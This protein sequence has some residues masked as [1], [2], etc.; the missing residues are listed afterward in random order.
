MIVHFE[1][2]RSCPDKPERLVPPASDTTKRPTLF[3][4][5]QLS[6]SSSKSVGRLTLSASDADSSEPVEPELPDLSGSELKSATQ[7]EA[8]DQRTVTLDLDL[9]QVLEHTTALAD[10]EQQATT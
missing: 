3:E 9:L 10:E 4:L 1:V 7:A 8:L 6:G 2:Y 5:V